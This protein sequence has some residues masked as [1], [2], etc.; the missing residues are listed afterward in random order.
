MDH[1]IDIPGAFLKPL[2]II[3]GEA[4]R[5]MHGLRSS[6]T[7]S[8]KFGEVYFSTIKHGRFKG[9]KRHREMVLNIVV[10]MGAIQFYLFDDRTNRPVYTTI[11][12][13]SET[14]YQRLTVPA[15]V[16]M[17]FR[18]LAADESLLTNIASIQHDPSECDTLPPGDA[19][20]SCFYL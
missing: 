19:K 17:G 3:H 11:E 7:Q 6:E 16:W 8:G 1:L 5:V 18:G 4:G 13:G 14:N 2:Q 10:P 12:L 15:G 9:W 20:F